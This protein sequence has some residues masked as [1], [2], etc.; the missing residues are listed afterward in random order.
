VRFD[1]ALEVRFSIDKLFELMSL[2]LE[3]FGI[4]T[5]ERRTNLKDELSNLYSFNILTGYLLQGE[6]V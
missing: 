4:K 6:K 3:K 2:L 5:V 1:E